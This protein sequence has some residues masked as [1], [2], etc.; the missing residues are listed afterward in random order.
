MTDRPETEVDGEV[1]TALQVAAEG[2]PSPAGVYLASLASGSRSTM[3]HALETMARWSSGGKVGVFDFPWHTLRYE[4]TAAIRAWLVDEYSIA[5]V[6]KHISALRC[7][8]KMAWR[9][10]LMTAED[11]H[12]A[13]DVPAIR[14]ETLVAGRMLLA[15][16]V[17]K[18]LGVCGEGVQGLRDAALITVLV[19]TGVRSAESVTMDVENINREDGS[20]VIRRGKGNKD[21]IVYLP[22]EALPVIDRWLAVRGVQPGPL[23]CPAYAM[24]D[25]KPRI[26]TGK[27]LSTTW[28]ARVVEK[29]TEKA[30]VDH[31][32]PH[33]FRRTFASMLLDR[34]I[35]I[36]TVQKLM[37][38]ANIAQ[39]ATY[40]RRGEE[41]KRK[42]VDTLGNLFDGGVPHG[43]G[44]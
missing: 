19:S 3:K 23:F 35:D 7:V 34:G 20:V 4:H 18:I 27:R 6:K 21:R 36:V 11:Y 32:T 2:A 29:V 30:G 8:L 38:H 40:D 28:V 31:V 39:T 37:G 13:R 22:K 17:T 12:R 43:V 10:G 9:M 42:A 15:S 33:D 26:R 41:T 1:V 5:S 44:R 14:G 24:P 25:G 16:E